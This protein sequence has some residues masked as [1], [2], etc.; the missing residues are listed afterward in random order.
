MCAKSI[1]ELEVKRPG[2]LSHA[3]FGW[4]GMVGGV[5][6]VSGLVTLTSYI[7]PLLNPGAV[8]P[9]HLQASVANGVTVAGT[10]SCFCTRNEKESDILLS[11]GP[12]CQLYVNNSGIHAEAMPI[13]GHRGKS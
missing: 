5:S 8:R 11:R 10:C 9:A 4:V 3:C 2:L 6:P 7:S 13:N 12:L 1:L